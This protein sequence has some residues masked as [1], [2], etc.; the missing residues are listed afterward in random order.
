MSGG[1]EMNKKAQIPTAILV[2]IA[3]VS[4]ILVLYAI[5]TFKE[6]IDSKSSSVAKI[7]DD[8]EFNQDYVKTEANLIGK[9]TLENCQSCNSEQLK[10]KYKQI[11]SQTENTFRYQ[12][13]GNFYAKIRNSEFTIENN[14]LI[15]KDLF[16]ESQSDF[17]KIRREFNLEISLNS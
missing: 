1:I 7:A 13:T 8:I 2:I 9:K 15:I 4:S 5:T 12:G 16:V 6:D 3:L 10:Q 11:A 17:N 14:R